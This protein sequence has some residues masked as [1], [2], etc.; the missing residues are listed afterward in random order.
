MVPAVAT[1][2]ATGARLVTVKR[3]AAPN[4]A[5][6]SH[7]DPDEHVQFVTDAI[8]PVAADLGLDP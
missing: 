1:I 5:K 7:A 3:T 4:Q 6:G 2:S 8:K